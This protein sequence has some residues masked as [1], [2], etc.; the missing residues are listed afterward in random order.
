[1]SEEAVVTEQQIE[2]A[3]AETGRKGRPRIF[4]PGTE[5]ERFLKKTQERIL[6]GLCKNGCGNKIEG[7]KITCQ[8]CADKQGIATL[9]SL[10]KRFPEE[11]RK[12]LESIQ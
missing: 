10:V 4:E 6:N 3:N 5:K 9:K 1:M 8:P 11:A 7:K 2:N 12:A